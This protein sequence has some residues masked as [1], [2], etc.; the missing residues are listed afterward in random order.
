MTQ[1]LGGAAIAQKSQRAPSKTR[2][3]LMNKLYPGRAPG[4][5]VIPWDRRAK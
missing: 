4:M 2:D 1:K 5:R 3:K